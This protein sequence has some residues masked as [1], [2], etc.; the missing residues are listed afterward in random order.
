M[1]RSFTR[2]NKLSV[3]SELNVTPLIDLA[4]SLLI[5]FMITTPVIEQYNRVNLPDQSSSAKQPPPP[6][7]DKY[8]TIDQAGDYFWGKIPISI[9]DL[10]GSTGP[11]CG[12]AGA[13]SYHSYTGRS[14]VTLSKSNRC[15]KLVK[16]K[17]F[18]QAQPR[19]PGKL[20]SLG[21]L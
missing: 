2:K 13:N 6:A 18:D 4:F 5:I 12:R 14:C 15:G 3:I 9:E 1:A 20:I 17:K 8:I 11:D 7:E 10:E 16:G 21:W 19:Y